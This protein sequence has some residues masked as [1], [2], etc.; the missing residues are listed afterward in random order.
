VRLIHQMEEV[1][2]KGLLKKQSYAHLRQN[3]NADPFR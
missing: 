3:L 1:H 2:S